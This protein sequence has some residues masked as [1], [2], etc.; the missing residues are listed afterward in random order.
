MKLQGYMKSLCLVDNTQDKLV[1][2]DLDS[3]FPYR[4]PWHKQRQLL[5]IYN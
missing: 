1:A 4:C 2:E 5:E 3:V